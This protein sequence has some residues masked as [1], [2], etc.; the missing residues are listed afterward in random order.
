MTDKRHCLNQGFINRDDVRGGSIDR[1][2]VKKNVAIDSRDAFK[3]HISAYT[4]V[5]LMLTADSRPKI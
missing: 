4:F 1:Q 5:S 2:E 3:T